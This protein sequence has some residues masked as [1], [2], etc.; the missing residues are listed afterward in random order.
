MR[1]EFD[2]DD[3][4]LYED[5]EFEEDQNTHTVT[6]TQRFLGMRPYILIE[7]VNGDVDLDAGG[8]TV[9]EMKLLA[10]SMPYLSRE[11]KRQ[12]KKRKKENN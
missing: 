4:D 1:E 2:I 5:D 6:V 10:N 3:P 9:E 12:Y 8:G 7:L 11:M